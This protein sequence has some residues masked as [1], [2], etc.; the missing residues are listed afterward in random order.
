M[1]LLSLLKA[2]AK[3]TQSIFRL[4]FHSVDRK[5]LATTTTTT[6]TN[7]TT[8]PPPPD[9]TMS[10][11][12]TAPAAAAS[13]EKSTII[14]ER[15]KTRLCK[16][17]R[18][19]GECAYFVRCMFAH[20]KED[21]RTTERNVA[22]GL[23]TESAVKNWQRA[24]ARAEEKAS[25]R[26][27]TVP[28]ESSAAPRAATPLPVP[29]APEPTAADASALDDEQLRPTNGAE[30]P[31][32]VVAAADP[33]IAA[34][35]G[36]SPAPLE[37]AATRTPVR[38]YRHDP[39]A[40]FSVWQPLLESASD[41]AEDTFNVQEPPMMVEPSSLEILSKKTAFLPGAEA[42]TTILLMP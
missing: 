26:R 33:L 13:N 3:S 7:N 24:K 27:A 8:T 11:P 20:G 18:K 1:T 10:H 36:M 14:A 16:T 37:K 29:S 6:T 28:K 39:Y 23:V 30:C 17:Y 34:F 5:L 19:T 15:F 21:L 31:D 12:T 9:T 41:S 22:D 2:S 4:P 25:K 32:S 42:H 35:A 40:Q 38:R